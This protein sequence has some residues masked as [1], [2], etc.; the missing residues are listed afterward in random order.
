MNSISFSSINFSNSDFVSVIHTVPPER[1]FY[2]DG[3]HLSDFGLLK[4]CGI[5]LSNLYDRIVPNLKRKNHKTSKN[6][7]SV[8]SHT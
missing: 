5:L 3:I 8:K 4:V 6:I 7:Q 2:K 1:L